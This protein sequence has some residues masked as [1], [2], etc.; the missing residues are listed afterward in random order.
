MV[1]IFVNGP[2]AGQAREVGDPPPAI[3]S[4]DSTPQFG[5]AEEYVSLYGLARM[6]E[7][8]TGPTFALYEHQADP[9]T[10][11]GPFE[12]LVAEARNRFGWHIEV[13]LQPNTTVSIVG[14]DGRSRSAESR[15]DATNVD[16]AAFSIAE[17][18]EWPRPV[19]P[20]G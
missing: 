8:D 10:G 7:Q 12:E 6:L 19:R 4:A 9:P 11:P 18:S 16:E 3:L 14:P 13:E 17:T 2:W 5:R 1:G 20:A 15:V